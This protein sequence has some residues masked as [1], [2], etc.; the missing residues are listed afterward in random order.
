VVDYCRNSEGLS[1][2]HPG[3][4]APVGGKA[5]ERITIGDRDG[6]MYL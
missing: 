2:D 5:R 4:V 1:D 6:L 3:E